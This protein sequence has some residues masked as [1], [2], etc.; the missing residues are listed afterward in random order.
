MNGV[1]FADTHGVGP[2]CCVFNEQRFSVQRVDHSVTHA[3]QGF[4][5]Q[6][7][8]AVHDREH[9]K[10]VL[11]P[12]V[13]RDRPVGRGKEPV[14]PGV[15]AVDAQRCQGRARRAEDAE[16]DELLRAAVGTRHARL[17]TSQNCKR[18]GHSSGTPETLA[19]SSKRCDP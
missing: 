4:P 11:P 3:V 16:P 14:E 8:L 18:Q 1:A 15:E 17:P 5:G 12:Q 2:P 6:Q 19:V 13:V 10:P 9:L 7:M